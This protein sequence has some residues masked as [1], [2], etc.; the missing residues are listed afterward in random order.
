MKTHLSVVH[1]YGV[2]TD[3][4]GHY[5]SG[6]GLIA[7]LTKALPN[8]RAAWK[9]GHLVVVGKDLSLDR[10]KQY[11][12]T[13][14]RPTSY[15]RWWAAVQKQ[16]T[17]AKTSAN[18]Q[19]ERN[20]RS[21]AEVQLLDAHIVGTSKNY[22]NPVLGTGGN[23][24]K[25][26]LAKLSSDASILISTKPAQAIKWLDTTLNGDTAAD[27]PDLS[28]AGTWFVFANKS[29]NSGQSWYREGRISPWSV[30]L[31]LEGT[32][33]LVGGVNRRLGAYSRPYAVFPF[34]AEP[35]RPNVVGEIGSS[36][37]EFW[38]PLWERPATMTELRSLFQR[39]LAQLGGRAARAPHEF[40]VS[41]RRAGVDSGV[42]EFVRYEFRQTTSSQVYE[43]IP[44]QRIAVQRDESK[45]Q[46]SGQGPNDA[47]LIMQLIESGWMG[48][49]PF[50][51]RDSKQRGKFAG[52][53]GPIEAS[54]ISVSEKPDDPQKWR[55]LLQLL[56]AT[57]FRIDRNRSWREK[58]AA[59]QL[60]HPAWFMRAWPDH[61]PE[62]VRIAQSVASIGVSTHA[63]LLTN[64][65]GVA[66]ERNG[67]LFFPKARPQQAVWNSGDPV[68]LFIQMV[69]RRLIDA[70]PTDEIPFHALCPCPRG[71]VNSFIAG[72]LDVE[73][74]ARWIP[75]LA[76]IDW[77]KAES[78]STHG[79]EDQ[80]A[81][82]GDALLHALFRPF[83][84]SGAIRV[85]KEVFFPENKR[86]R[87]GLSMHL[88]HLLQH[89]SFNEAVQVA[90]NAYRAAGH[91][92]VK[93]SGDIHIHGDLISAAILIPMMSK[94]VSS[95]IERWLQVPKTF[96][97]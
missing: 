50:E 55:H 78:G 38:A 11:L 20:R 48:R 60:L 51:P 5:L 76:L 66:Q 81:L 8:I 49:L 56:A 62:E 7:A 33:I 65:F 80:S 23:I 95:G 61:V 21:A 27:L 47:D 64:I 69:H 24:G 46:N 57:Q 58:C 45:P 40:A 15:H 35:S 17:N 18:L 87:A 84:H 12:L 22:F 54:I 82:D 83:F 89:G 41:A 29:F 63:P 6:L 16:D 4:L 68:P 31:A 71:L 14:W 1:C 25:R 96:S 44:R 88:Y 94:D 91:V 85:R 92:I 37:G 53:Q 52:L 42:S 34:I 2:N 9:D 36:K 30:L 3:S 70:S 39:G 19:R 43:A 28:G 74:I 59:L 77:S 73:M 13:D 97:N 86:P 75:P 79:Y 32:R 10:I 26:D 67:T 90:S 72:V 93:T